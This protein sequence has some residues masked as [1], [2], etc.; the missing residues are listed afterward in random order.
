MEQRPGE[1]SPALTPVSPQ[2][3]AEWEQYFDLRWR[4]LRAPW[5]QPRGSEKDELETHSQHLMIPGANSRPLAIGRLHF[6]SPDESQV[7]F[8]AVEPEAQGRGL[9]GVILNE[10][11]RYARVMGAKAIVLN[12][13]QDVEGFYKKHGFITVGA[14][15]TLFDVVK[16]VRMR[17][18]LSA[19]ASR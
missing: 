8:M 1:T 17:K 7:R 9:G 10:L 13:R 18:D 16:H 12:A 14:A 3:A 6:N 11:E 15:P 19:T 4:V 2:T 5:R